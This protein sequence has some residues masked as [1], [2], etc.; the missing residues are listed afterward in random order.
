MIR[1]IT[2]ASSF[3]LAA[4]LIA[5]AQTTTGR[6]VSNPRGGTLNVGHITSTGETVPN[7]GIS[8][9]SGTTSLDLGALRRD[10]EIQNSICRGC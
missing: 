1:T 2:L 10:T 9:G 7:P 4:G 8:Q 3:F 6:S 5:S